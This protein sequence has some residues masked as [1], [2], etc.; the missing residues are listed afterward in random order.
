MQS[1]QNSTK[2]CVFHRRRR[3]SNKFEK[4][5]S[6]HSWAV[7]Q[8]CANNIWLICSKDSLLR[9]IIKV[10]NTHFASVKKYRNHCLWYLL[11]FSWR[12]SCM[13]SGV[14]DEK[15][16]WRE[17]SLTRLSFVVDRRLII[18][19]QQGSKLIQTMMDNRMKQ[20]QSFYQSST[21]RQRY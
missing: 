12:G 17:R 4:V 5:S 2:D 1:S 8:F 19:Y 3:Q 18:D 10:Y 11:F 20:W 7:T 16:A 6:M 14:T 15:R 21:W 9:N 13:A